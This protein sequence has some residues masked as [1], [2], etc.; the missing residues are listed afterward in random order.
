RYTASVGGD[1]DTSI[2]QREGPPLTGKIAALPAVED[3]R[4]STFVFGGLQPS[5][6]NLIAFAGTRPLSTRIIEGRD[7]D[8]S[9][10]HEFVADRTF[11]KATGAHVGEH[12]AFQSISRETIESGEGFGGKPDGPAFP[13]T[14]VGILKSPDELNTDGTV[15]VFPASLLRED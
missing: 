2:T 5:P 12:F 3:L 15:A 6:E 14:L 4:A 10:P 11:V 9:N 1:V 7:L 13:A 8:E